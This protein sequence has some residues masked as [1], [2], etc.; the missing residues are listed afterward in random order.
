MTLKTIYLIRHATPDWE[1]KDIPYHVP[2]GP[3]LTDLG[4]AEAEALGL[5][6]KTAGVRC[7]YVSPLE[8]TLHTAQIAAR[9]AGADLIVDDRLREMPPGEPAQVVWE[10]VAALVEQAIAEADGGPVGL[11]SHGGPVSVILEQMG[12]DRAMLKSQVFDHG[13][14]IPPAGAWQMRQAGPDAAWQFALVFD[15]KTAL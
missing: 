5:Y 9:I 2:P 11:V 7:L 15:P 6:L 10:R 3:P 1:R 14:P 8:R 13:N 12:V 4:L